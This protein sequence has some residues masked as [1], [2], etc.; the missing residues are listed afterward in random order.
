MRPVSPPARYA[1]VTLVRIC[2]LPLFEPRFPAAGRHLYAL[3]RATLREKRLECWVE[4]GKRRRHGAIRDLGMRSYI[5]HPSD[6][7]IEYQA[8]AGCPGAQQERLR[9][10]GEGGL[11]F[12]SRCALPVGAAITLRIS[13][14]QPDFEVRG[15]VVWCRAESGVFDIGVA[16]LDP[17]DLFQV[18]M[19]EQI[20][21]IEQYKADVLA[22]EG[23]R[24]NG[25]Q[26][27]SEWIQK[28]ARDF[29]QLREDDNS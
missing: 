11:S 16:F 28:F 23:R 17:S 29:P 2:A 18:R 4:A 9:N 14:V 6:I 19:V 12:R 5:R 24:L 26:A 25:E 20:C 3:W 13:Q 15:Q 27:A 7:P 8:D 1:A 21:H 22:R 10:I